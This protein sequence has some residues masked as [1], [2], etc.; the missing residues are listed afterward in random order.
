MWAQTPENYGGKQD[1]T[2]ERW[3]NLWKNLNQT[4]ADLTFG[5]NW[6]EAWHREYWSKHSCK[7]CAVLQGIFLQKLSIITWK[8][9]GLSLKLMLIVM[10]FNMH[11][12]H[13]CAFILF[14]TSHNL[15]CYLSD[16]TCNMLSFFIHFI[17]SLLVFGIRSLHTFNYSFC[18]SP[19]SS[20]FL[21]AL[22][23]FITLL[24]L[25]PL[26][27]ALHLHFSTL[28]LPL[29]YPPVLFPLV[30]LL[31]PT[32]PP[33]PL[34]FPANSSFLPAHFHHQSFCLFWLDLHSLSLCSPQSIILLSSFLSAR[35]TSPFHLATLCCCCFWA[36]LFCWRL[37]LKVMLKISFIIQCFI[38]HPSTQSLPSCATQQLH[39]LY[40]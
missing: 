10:L 24:P 15:I 18:P 27:S 3:R 35:F 37:R 2:H 33:P 32:L 16:C 22:P 29:F 4:R 26:L 14:F 39:V 19:P 40:Q 23:L 38:C 17:S 6:S 28:F 34:L 5:Q 31:I 30:I 36:L 12:V 9:D 13:L 20:L 8:R 11:S 25:P 21:S 1:L 7:C